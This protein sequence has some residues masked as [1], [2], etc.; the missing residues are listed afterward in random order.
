MKFENQL[1]WKVYTS[2]GLL[3]GAFLNPLDAAT[4]LAFYGDGTMLKTESATGAT[5]TVWTEGLSGNASR[6][7]DKVAD[8]AYAARDFW[9]D[10]AAKTETS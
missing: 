1:K 10:V 2:R 3:I 8:A 6:G 5:I 7:Y 4:L 9:V